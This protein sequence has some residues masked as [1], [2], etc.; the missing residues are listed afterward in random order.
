M[1]EGRKL[2]MKE[3]RLK[4]K[5]Y[6]LKPVVNILSLAL[7]LFLSSCQDVKKPERPENLISKEKMVDILTDVYIT[8]AARNINNKLIKKTGVKL[9]SLVY[10]KFEIDSLQFVESN[11]FYCSDLET[12]RSLL[13]Q[14][15]DR[16]LEMQ[17][18]KDSIY[19]IAKKKDSIAK[20][21]KKIPKVNTTIIIPTEND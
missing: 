8:N 18:E 20:K 15:Q 21:A 13:S 9:D 5:D 11:A 14:V 3:V 7:V 10:S 17:T 2:K 1:I 6:K 19:A 16:M 4:T 12:Y